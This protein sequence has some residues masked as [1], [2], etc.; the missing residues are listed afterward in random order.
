M[1][2]PKAPT[3]LGRQI[4]Q[5]GSPTHTMPIAAGKANSTESASGWGKG[6][7]EVPCTRQVVGTADKNRA[8]SM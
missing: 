2:A 6:W 7:E 3:P 5:T 8:A 1:T 4:A